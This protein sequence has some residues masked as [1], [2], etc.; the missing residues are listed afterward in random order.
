ML[1]IIL[2]VLI[3]VI[4]GGLVIALVESAGHMIFPP[5]EG[6]NLKDPE[7]LKSIMQEIP[8]GAKA[9]VLVAWGLGVF[10]GGVVARVISRRAV[11][12]AWVVA[13]VLFA[14]AAWTMVMIPHPL[15]MMIGA[16]LV[17]LAGGFA[18]NKITPAR[19]A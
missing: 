15:W 17:T 18:A 12:A 1:R 4:A 2:G 7:E 8:V 16:V 11:Y 14:G 13:G 19:G 9:A 6:V 3:G 5:P 10:A